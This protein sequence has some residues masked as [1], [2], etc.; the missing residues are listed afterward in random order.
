MTDAT[1]AQRTVVLDGQR[2]QHEREALG[3]TISQV[4]D[5]IAERVKGYNGGVSESTYRRAEGSKSVFIKTARVIAEAFDIPFE[6]LVMSSYLQPPLADVDRFLAQVRLVLRTWLNEGYDNMD[7]KSPAHPEFLLRL[8]QNWKGWNHY[9]PVTPDEPEWKKNEMK[10][11][12]EDCA[13]NVAASLL[14]L[15]LLEERDESVPLSSPDEAPSQAPPSPLPS[16]PSY[17]RDD[18]VRVDGA[19]VKR[20]RTERG[21]TQAKLAQEMDSVGVGWIRKIEADKLV[22]LEWTG[23]GRAVSAGE[24]LAVTLEVELDTLILDLLDSERIKRFR[25]ERKWGPEQFAEH[26]NVGVEVV[27]RAETGQS[28]RRVETRALAEALNVPV[29][30]LLFKEQ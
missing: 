30:D 27:G 1:E 28:V 17:T 7:A 13:F 14:A 11:I 22:R 21:L 3:L 20:L 26:A 29:V 16:R 2:L 5:F 25:A 18:L 6:E 15:E 4:P 24:D 12:Y 9:R 10:D 8:D 19:L 23:N